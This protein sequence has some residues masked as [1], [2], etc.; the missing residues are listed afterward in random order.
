MRVISGPRARLV[1][2]LAGVALATGGCTRLRGHQGY[3]INPDLVNSV[4]A[5]VDN[6]NSVARVL[7]QPTFASQFDQSEWYYVSRDTRYFAYNRPKPVGETVLRIRFDDKGV[8]R[9][10]DR[11]GL[12][13]VA[14]ITPFRKITPTLGRKRSFFRDLFGNIGAVG[15]PIGG[16]PQQGGGGRTQP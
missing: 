15:A 14:K 1:V 2:L 11:T 5:G 8:V 13:Q 12:E 7:G 16:G 4:Q 6:R 3:V 9:S 10:I